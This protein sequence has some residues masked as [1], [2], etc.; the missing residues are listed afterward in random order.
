MLVCL[1]LE[2]RGISSWGGG[3]LRVP[4]GPS[5]R[6]E[7]RAACDPG[8]AASAGL[9]AGMATRRRCWKAG[10]KRGDPRGRIGGSCWQRAERGE[11][12]AA[13]RVPARLREEGLIER[14]G[15]EKTGRERR[16]KPKGRVSKRT[17][18]G[19]KGLSLRAHRRT[20]RCAAPSPLAPCEPGDSL[21]F[22]SSVLSLNRAFRFI[23]AGRGTQRSSLKHARFNYFTQVCPGPWRFSS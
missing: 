17:E 21:N 19:A 11:Q 9:G 1:F 6:S 15:G 4:V 23:K 2:V 14:R 12:G 8:G 5:R 22:D 20:E 18:S 3:I 10:V 16:E 7:L 13:Q